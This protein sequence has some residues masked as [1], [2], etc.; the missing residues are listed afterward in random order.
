MQRK[1]KNRAAEKSLFFLRTV[2]WCGNGDVPELMLTVGR[3]E[4][5]QASVSTKC[6]RNEILEMVV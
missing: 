6:S 5:S 3:R 2:G 1:H 4:S